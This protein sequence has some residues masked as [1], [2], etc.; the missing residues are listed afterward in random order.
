MAGNNVRQKP[1]RVPASLPPEALD[2]LC[3]MII[4]KLQARNLREPAFQ[5]GCREFESRLP[6]HGL[7]AQWQSGRLITDWSQVRNLPSPLNHQFLIPNYS[8]P[9]SLLNYH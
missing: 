8:T 7:V 5:A 2:Q 6:L 4:A 3:N 1:Q 9:S